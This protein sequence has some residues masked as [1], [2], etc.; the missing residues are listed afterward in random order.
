MSAN[1]FILTR[2][3]SVVIVLTL[4]LGGG[5]RQHLWSDNLIYILLLPP[6]IVGFANIANTRL[7]GW[8]KF[9]AVCF[10][11]LVMVQFLP[12]GLSGTLPVLEGL[13]SPTGLMTASPYNTQ[14]SLLAI[15]CLVGF[16]LFVSTLSDHEQ[17]LL[18]RYVFLGFSISAAVA[19]IQ[20]SF[21]SDVAIEGVLPF[22]ITSGL[23]A[24]EN[25]FSSLAM[26]VIP[27][28]AWRFMIYSRRPFI[29]ALVVFL[30]VVLMFA[31]GSRAGMAISTLLALIS[32]GWFRTEHTA[33]TFK[34]GTLVLA[35][36][37]IVT[38]YYFFDISA[39]L[40]KDLRSIYNANTWLAIKDN[41]LSGT[42]YGSFLLIYPIYETTQFITANFANHAHNDYLELLLEGGIIVV[43][44]FLLF[45]TQII[46]NLFRTGLTQAAGLSIFAI[47]IH[48]LVDYPLRTMAIA[49]VFVLLSAI[50]LSQSELNKLQDSERYSPQ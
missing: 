18:I 28:L 27:L 10:I 34:I 39:I 12:F 31:V 48:S 47:L 35:T 11:A 29:F 17:Q 25:H 43:P 24:N 16:G 19:I 8:A 45:V 32:F 15:I 42:G 49:I 3:T 41:W 13:P 2:Y 44:V 46:C 6:V 30:V 23:F 36:I 50:I 4:V 40:E 7:M 21:S 33:R 1:N 14:A 38:L 9:M 22:A 20:L 5:T 37:G 26:V